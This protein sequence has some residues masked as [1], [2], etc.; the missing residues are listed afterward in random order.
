MGMDVI[1][2]LGGFVSNKHGASLGTPHV[3][4]LVA[5]NSPK[6]NTHCVIEEKDFHAEFD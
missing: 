6:G 5:I 1:G 4:G 3:V 2:Q